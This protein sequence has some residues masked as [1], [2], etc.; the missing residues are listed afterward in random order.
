MQQL[1]LHKHVTCSLIVKE[2]DGSGYHSKYGRRISLINLVEET[3]LTLH[4]K[5]N[6]F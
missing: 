5:C 1:E 6:L 4:Y 3:A 2:L